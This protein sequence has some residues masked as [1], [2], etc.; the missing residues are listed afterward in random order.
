[1]RI[2]AFDAIRFFL[3]AYIVQPGGT[4][5]ESD[6]AKIS[7]GSTWG[8]EVRTFHFFRRAKPLCIQSLSLGALLVH[9]AIM[10]LSC[11]YH[12]IMIIKIIVR[13][14]YCM[15]HLLRPSHKSTLLLPSQGCMRLATRK[16]VIMNM[17]IILL[18]VIVIIFLLMHQGR[19]VL[20]IERLRGS[21][22]LGLSFGFSICSSPHPEK[23]IYNNG[24]CRA[25]CEPQT[26]GHAADSDRRS[27][28]EAMH[29][30]GIQDLGTCCVCLA[31]SDL[32]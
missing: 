10:L 20:C 25:S 24:K 18:I 8:A 17:I 28:L 29:I 16:A 11:Y 27:Q 2:T 9:A 15:L 23:G 1:M 3:I 21:F 26:A 22:V 30:S 13:L 32:A 19:G 12:V 14:L 5:F 6:I 4:K 31:A 7:C